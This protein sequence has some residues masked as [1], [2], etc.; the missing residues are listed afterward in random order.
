MGK[1]QTKYLGELKRILHQGAVKCMGYKSKTRIR[2]SWITKD[3]TGAVLKEQ[4]E[5]K[6]WKEYIKDLYD[7]NRKLRMEDF[8][9]LAEA[10]VR[11]YKLRSSLIAGEIELK[12]GQA[13][14]VY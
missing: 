7:K 6:R 12:N 10:S 9:L 2:K 14:G 13:E 3:K 8:D 4:E 5:I 11:E 1:E